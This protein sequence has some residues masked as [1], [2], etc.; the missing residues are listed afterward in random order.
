MVVLVLWWFYCGV[1]V[2]LELFGY[3]CCGGIIVVLKLGWL[4]CGVGVVVILWGCWCC[5]GIK[6]V[7][8]LC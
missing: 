1:G 6:G 8:V 2:V 5:A 7:F 4:Y 3:W